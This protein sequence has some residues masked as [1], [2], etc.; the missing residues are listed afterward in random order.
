MDT[1]D[2]DPDLVD[3][4]VAAPHARPGQLGLGGRR[5]GILGAAWPHYRPTQQHTQNLE[6]NFDETL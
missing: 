6:W 4:L 1:I 2:N 3:D 5:R